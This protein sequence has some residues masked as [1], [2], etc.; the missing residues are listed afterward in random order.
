MSA[1]VC[2]F[3]GAPLPE[4]SRSN[5]RFCDQSCIDKQAWADP[6][7]RARSRA[8]KRAWLEANRERDRE[9][10]RAWKQRNRE[11]VRAYDS[12]Y[13]ATHKGTCAD[14]GGPTH[15]QHD[16]GTCAD[17]HARRAQ[18]RRE[19]IAVMWRDGQ[20]L[21]EIADALDSTPNSI[22]VT[23]HRMRRDGWDL[24][25]RRRRAVAA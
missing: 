8:K 22:Q 7:R 4:G 25:S 6:V 17:C 16:G 1:R 12:E 15:R 23:V 3:C 2:E 18:E 14:C 13:D 24:P 10:S 11:R 19:Q 5:K 20:T 9:Y 21:R